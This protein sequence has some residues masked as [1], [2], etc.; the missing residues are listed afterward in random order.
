MTLWIKYGIIKTGK[1]V[2][3]MRKV[4]YKKLKKLMIDKD[5]SKRDLCNEFSPTTVSKL[6]KNEYVNMDILRR[7][8]ERL[9][10]DIGDI[11]SF[12]KVD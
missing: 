11:M 12:E 2:V 1:G 4:S 8:C 3:K 6:W 5:V 7:L 10:C 9:D